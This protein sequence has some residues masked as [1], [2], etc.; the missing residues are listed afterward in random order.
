[1]NVDLEILLI[2]FVFI[3]ILLLTAFD[4]EGEE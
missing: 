1:M 2:A 3:N 4:D